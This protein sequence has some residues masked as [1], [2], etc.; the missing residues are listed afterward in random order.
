MRG[1]ELLSASDVSL[2]L[3]DPFGLWHNRFGDQ[4]LKDPED[5]YAL[6]LQEQ[7]LRIEKELLTKRHA[8]FTDIQN[9]GF[10]EAV[11]HT[12]KLLQKGD[13]VIYGG[14]LYSKALGLR[15]RPD[16]IKINNGICIIEEY[17]LASKLDETHKIQALVYAYIL[18]KGYGIANETLVVSRNNEEFVIPYN[19]SEIVE[20]ILRARE[21]LASDTPPYPVYN[22]S[23][24][25]GTLQNR[26][27]KELRDVTLAWHVGAI[28]AKMLHGMGIHT[29]KELSHLKP[30]ALGTI[31][32]LG[33]KKVPQIVNSVKAQ[34]SKSI[35]KVGAWKPIEETPELEL[36][37]DLEGTSELFQDDPEWNCIYLIGL[38]PRSGGEEEPYLAFL[39]WKPE[40]EKAILSDFIEFLRGKTH[41]Y[42]LYHW[43]HY[44]KTQLKKACT[45]H[46]FE[47]AY[48]TLILPYLVDLCVAAQASYVLPTPGYSIKVVAPYFG[49]KWSQDSTEVDAMKSA[50]IW[51]KQAIDGGSG[52]HMEKVLKYNEDDCKAMIIVKDGFDKIERKYRP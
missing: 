38:I 36:F 52:S 19:E 39:A 45:R 15:A 47:E 34:L 11:Q 37:L 6:F 50:M 1:I 41:A 29:L 21:I 24:N 40:D 23:S 46:G 26:R 16:L 31:K 10:D 30:E 51:F 5:E 14:A 18:K 25:W 44:E 22:C 43:H 28:H 13:L 9:E 42:L 27:A 17:K 7:G 20:A 3:S 33:N 32:G 48:E 35:I 8:H 4:K 49:F 12:A 2:S